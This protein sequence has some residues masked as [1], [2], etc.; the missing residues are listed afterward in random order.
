M[1]LTVSRNPPPIVGLPD[2]GWLKDVLGQVDIEPA[3]LMEAL[4]HPSLS[5]PNYQRLEFLGDRVL[6]CVMAEWLM[7]RFPDEAEGELAKRFADLVCTDSCAQVARQ[8]DLGRWIRLAPSAANSGVQHM[9]N[10]LADVCEALIGA[11]YRASGMVA[12][13]RFIKQHW[14]GL[15][16][17]NRKAPQHPKSVLQEWAQGR[18]LPIPDYEVTGREGPDHAPA[19]TVTVAVRGF[20]SVSAAGASKQDAERAAAIAFLKERAKTS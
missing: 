19:F 9:D 18:G 15:I 6:G 7:D 4:T 3:L 16:A 17:Q 11:L 1:A 12:A 13:L 20:P 8:I 2:T 5:G 10:V 14:A